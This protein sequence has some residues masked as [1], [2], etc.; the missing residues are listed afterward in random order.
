MIVSL[1]VL[2]EATEWGGM[3][4]MRPEILRSSVEIK[5][6]FLLKGL[7]CWEF[8]GF[9]IIIFAFRFVERKKCR[10][11]IFI[12]SDP[13]SFEENPG[14]APGHHVPHGLNVIQT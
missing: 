12:A 2:Q 10:Y 13:H 7:D 3:L 9:F 8:G 6:T 14:S 4:W 5:K 1:F 11:D